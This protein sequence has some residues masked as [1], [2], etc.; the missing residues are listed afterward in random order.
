MKRFILP[1]AILVFIG[2]NSC[3]KIY[4]AI[5]VK[6]DYSALSGNHEL[7]VI[8]QDKSNP[9]LTNTLY[10][11]TLDENNEHQTFID[12][13][14]SEGYNYILQVDS[15]M[16]SDTISDF[17]YETKGRNCNMHVE[18]VSYLFNGA[19]RTDMTLVIQ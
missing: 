3:C 4:L 19:R 1:L 6:V 9:D 12:L 5:G 18:N 17:S 2:I 10:V 13:E 11:I 7:K 14:Q 16:Y 15:L 8:Q